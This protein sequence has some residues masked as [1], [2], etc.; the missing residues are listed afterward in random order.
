[1]VKTNVRVTDA[2]EMLTNGA[3]A[4]RNTSVTG[5]KISLTFCQSGVNATIGN[6]INSVL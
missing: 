6:T 5:K 4:A 2:A 3:D 1:M